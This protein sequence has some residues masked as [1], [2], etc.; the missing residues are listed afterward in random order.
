MND[1][2]LDYLQKLSGGF[3]QNVRKNWFV[4]NELSFVV[5]LLRFKTILAVLDNSIVQKIAFNVLRCCTENELADLLFILRN[6]VFNIAVYNNVG[7]VFQTDMDNWYRSYLLLLGP[8]EQQTNSLV[9]VTQSEVLISNDWF[10]LP[11]LIFVNGDQGN[12][13]EKHKF[14]KNLMEKDI[15]QMTFKFTNLQKRNFLNHITPTEELMFLMISFMGPESTFLEPDICELLA[16]CVNQFFE[17]HSD[18]S[19][20]FDEKFEGYSFFIFYYKAFDNQTMCLFKA[21]AN[22]RICTFCFWTIS[23]GL[24]METKHLVHWLWFLWRKNMTT[25]GVKWFGLS[26]P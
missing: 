16:D 19:F 7:D 26:M 21:K 1:I 3:N 10:W 22:S 14:I 2:L 11:L 17:S 8:I 25:S 15:I 23:K 24:A 5:N 13:L 4:R 20:S 18:T 6:I 12:M 9:H